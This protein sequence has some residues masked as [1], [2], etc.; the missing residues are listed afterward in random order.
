M[1]NIEKDFS[2]YENKIEAN[3]TILLFKSKII[4]YLSNLPYN[5]I[6]IVGNDDFC[7][8]I[9]SMLPDNIEVEFRSSITDLSL[10]ENYDFIIDNFYDSNYVKY[11]YCNYSYRIFDDIYLEIL[12][13]C[14]IDFVTKNKLNFYF[15]ETMHKDKLI[16]LTE[17]EKYIINNRMPLGDVM[18]YLNEIY[19]DNNE[20]KNFVLDG[21]C[22]SFKVNH[23]GLF[24]SLSDQH[25]KYVNIE[26]GIR[27]TS[28]SPKTFCNSIYMF[29]PCITRGFGVTDNY[30]IASYLQKKINLNLTKEYRVVNCGTGGKRGIINDLL[31]LL[32]THYLENDIIIII[33][34][35]ENT[36]EKILNRRNVPIYELSSLFSRPHNCGKW[37]LHSESHI[38]HVGNEVISNYIYNILT[39]EGSIDNKKNTKKSIQYNFENKKILYKKYEEQVNNYLC[40]IRREYPIQFKGNETIGSIVMNCNPFTLGHKYLVEK[41]SKEVDV[42]YVFIV[43]ENR[44]NFSYEDRLK[45]V[46]EGLKDIRN[47]YILPSGEF[48]VSYQT[49]PEYFNRDMYKNHYIEKCLD[50]E[51]FANFIAPELHIAI[52]FVGNEPYDNIT[53]EYNQLMKRELPL[54]NI[55]L[56]EIKRKE[57]NGVPISASYVRKLLQKNDYDT[58]KKIVPDSTFNYLK[59]NYHWVK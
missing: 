34:Q 49:F 33:N 36:F 20:C 30:T 39:K 55:S 25:D 5:N 28:D 2:L 37:I 16:N 50:I 43:Q 22:N 13:N 32:S 26:N 19:I 53:R 18:S 11:I 51:I 23:N 35:L 57:S 59:S 10:L 15:L 17:E 12:T 27:L 58:I 9:R 52:R 56:K 14:A 47:A 40:E 42:L 41:A 38:N 24:Y 54:Y 46:N 6:L 1:G 48:I 21:G 4:Q 31:Y 29:G 45:M 8:C 3:N 7:S 44:S